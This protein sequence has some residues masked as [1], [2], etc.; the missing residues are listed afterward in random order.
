MRIH[1]LPM[2][3]F[4]S[5]LVTGCDRG[6]GSSGRSP[7]LPKIVDVDFIDELESNHD[8]TDGLLN[9]EFVDTVGDMV[10]LDQFQGNKNV[11]LVF[12]RGFSGQLCPF[13]TT[14]TSRL[15]K[16]YGEITKRDTEVLLVYPGSRAQLPQF[17]EASLQAGADEKFP[18]PVLLDE[19]LAAVTKLHIKAN[20]AHPS[21]FIVDK[22]GN[23][24]LAYVGSNPTDRPSIKAILSK[25]DSLAE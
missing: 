4:S 19:D 22:G 9:L 20:L 21:T 18:F 14:Q 8:E 24:Q 13:C 12:T 2:I 15:I 6:G 1:I 3:L 17:Q 7:S 16:N 5:L 25:L 11:L 23:I 10:R